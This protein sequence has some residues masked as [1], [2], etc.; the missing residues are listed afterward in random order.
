VTRTGARL[1]GWVALV[2]TIAALGYSTNSKPPKNVLF[3]W[4]TVVNEAVLFGLILLIVLAISWGLPR[5]ETFA[6]RPPRS[7]RGAL[8]L[9]AVVYVAVIAI[10]AIVDPFLHP[11]REQGLTSGHWEGAHAAAF[12]A[13]LVAFAVLGPI[14]EEL[15]FRG[16]GFRLLERW[17][18]PVAILGTGIAFGLWHGLVDALPVLVAFGWLL[19]WLRAR[20]GSLYPCI[21]L[22]G[23]FNAIQLIVSVTT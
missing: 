13:N 19:G 9:I 10:S 20:T 12:A 8:G 4:D 23:L 6:L 2:G 11:G 22:H 17:G 16:L 7:W 1:A 15:T 5:R 14:T 18:Q 21:L 3:R